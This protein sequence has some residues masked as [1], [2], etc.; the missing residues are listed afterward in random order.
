MKTKS[1]TQKAK[2]AFSIDCTPKWKD[3]V[4]IHAEAAANGSESAR[5]EL[6]RMAEAADKWNEYCK[7][8]KK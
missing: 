6:F 5:Q 4:L 7:V 8:N 2:K 1:N 3:I